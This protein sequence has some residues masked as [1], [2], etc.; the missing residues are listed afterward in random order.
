MSKLS[1]FQNCKDVS[2]GNTIL[3]NEFLNSIKVGIHKDRVEK[4]RQIKTKEEI[5]HAKS[6]L[7]C[8]TVSGNFLVRKKDSLIKHSGYIAIDFDDINLNNLD[9]IRNQ[10]K[11]DIY[12]YSLFTS[13]SGNGFCVIVKIDPH[14]HLESFDGLYNYYLDTYKL[15]PDI[16][17]KD[18]TRLRF[19]SYDP[20]LCINE[21]SELFKIY[22]SKK[23]PKATPLVVS[24]DD[25]TELVNQIK[26]RNI[27][28]T[29]PYSNWLNIA[30][31]LVDECGES[32][33]NMFHVISSQS[34]KYNQQECDSFYNYCV[35]RDRSGSYNNITIGTLFY[36]AKQVGINPISKRTKQIT[37]ITVQAKKQGRDQASVERLLK[38]IVSPGQEVTA[39]D[40]SMIKKVLDSNIIESSGEQNIFDKLEMFIYGNYNFKFNEILNR[41]EDKGKPVEDSDLNSIFIEAKKCVDIKLTKPDFLTFINSKKIINI[42]R[43]EVFPI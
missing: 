4:V 13:V 11:S 7:P 21:K 23:H 15:L 25:I 39:E 22:R 3:I 32:G 17:C 26:S 19:V 31:A 37:E 10:L 28:I 12:T 9:K 41:L 18:V 36:Y 1:F 2:N 16:A 24:Q 14:K 29:E 6:N 40:S 30:F 35:N 8:V 33:R 42:I 27:D 43:K 5:T 20:E 34:P 38:E